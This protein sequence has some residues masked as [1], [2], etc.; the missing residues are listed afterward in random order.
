MTR[1]F[2][3]YLTFTGEPPGTQPNLPSGS[4]PNLPPGSHL[5][6]VS[7]ASSLSQ[8]VWF[9][10]LHRRWFSVRIDRRYSVYFRSWMITFGG[11]PLDG[12]DGAD[13][14]VD[15]RIS[16]VSVVFAYISGV[17]EMN[18]GRAEGEAL[19]VGPEER[20]GRK[21]ADQLATLMY[22]WVV[23][24]G[25]SKS[26]ITIGADSTKLNTRYKGDAIHFLAYLCFAHK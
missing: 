3:P 24:Y 21:A 2:H 5:N 19:T 17:V 6:A 20:M 25:I 18:N 1:A 22:K 10:S 23:E 14:A 15:G 8:S 12:N 7:A 4:Q 9:S 13:D 16:S 11:K 26:L